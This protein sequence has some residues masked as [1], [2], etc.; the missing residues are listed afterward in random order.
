MPT[1]R[2]DLSGDPSRALELLDHNINPDNIEVLVIAGKIK[3]DEKGFVAALGDTETIK[4]V[5]QELTRVKG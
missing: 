2:I 4:K 1:E 5:I 3:Y